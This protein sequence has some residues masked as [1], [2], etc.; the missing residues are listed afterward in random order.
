[1]MGHKNITTTRPYVHI[2]TDD[3]IKK[4]KEMNLLESFF[5]QYSSILLCPITKY[6]KFINSQTR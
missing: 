6:F 4:H 5:K 1:M 3:L 2:D